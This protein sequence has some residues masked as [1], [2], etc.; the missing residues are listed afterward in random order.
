MTEPKLNPGPPEIIICER[1]GKRRHPSEHVARASMRK[2]SGRVKVY[3][4]R[5]CGD[6]HVTKAEQG[7]DD[8]YYERD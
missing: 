5:H 7:K 4:C 3:R 1:T 6:L 8:S 2:A